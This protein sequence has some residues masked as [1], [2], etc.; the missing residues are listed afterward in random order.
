MLAPVAPFG[1]VRVRD[2]ERLPDHATIFGIEQDQR[3]AREERRRR[4]L[5]VGG[6]ADGDVLPHLVPEPQI[7]GRPKRI[8]PDAPADAAVSL[9]EPEDR[10]RLLIADHD[11]AADHDRTGRE[12]GPVD[13]RLPPEPA[14]LRVE[15][16]EIA[17][18][19]AIEHRV[20][21]DG[22]GARHHGRGGELPL[23][24]EPG[25][26]GLAPDAAPAAL[27]RVPC[28]SCPNIGQSEPPPSSS[29]RTVAGE[30]PDEMRIAA[31]PARSHRVDPIMMYAPRRRST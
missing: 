23:D 31:A 1:V 15:R 13:G 10:P 8:G 5:V 7:A 11:S 18:R 24:L 3:P 16:V 29:P 27:F 19:I 9:V 4:P 17:C 25:H 20:A 12:G 6:H 14:R 21:D 26:V 22:R 28:G 2:R 30:S